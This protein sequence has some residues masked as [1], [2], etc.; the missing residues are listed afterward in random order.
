LSVTGSADDVTLE[1][2]DDK[3]LVGDDGFDKVADR[4]KA[5]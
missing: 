2:L 3:F 5:D 4:D 1:L